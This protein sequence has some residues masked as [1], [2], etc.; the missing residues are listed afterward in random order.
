MN[1]QKL[2]IA[3]KPIRGAEQDLLQ[4]AVVEGAMLVATDTGKMY[5]DANGKRV[6][7]GGSGSPF[8][9]AEA[10]G[11]EPDE[12]G[13]YTLSFDDLESK[14]MLPQVDGLIINSD[15]AF[16]RI[17]EV[18]AN[19]QTMLCMMIAVSGTN[20]DGPTGGGKA[21]SIKGK[22]LS[23]VTLVNGQKMSAYF[24]ATAASLGDG[25]YL[26]D[27]LTISWSLSVTATGVVYDSG[28]FKVASGVEKEFEFGSR[29]RESTGTTLSVYATGVNSGKS[30]IITY[31][32]TTVELLLYESE[33]FSNITPQTGTFTYY[34]NVS[35]SVEKILDFYLDGEL[36]E[37]QNLTKSATGEQ[38]CT[39]RNVSH[40]YHTISVNLSQSI[41][42]EHGVGVNEPLEFEIAVNNGGT[43]PIIWLGAYNKEYYNYDAI[44]IPYRVFDP[45]GGT[46][47]VIFVKGIAE[48]GNRQEDTAATKFSIWQI[49]DATL[50]VEN[51]YS[52]R[53]EKSV[54]VEG[55]SKFVSR[56]IKFTVAKDPTRD[57]S[58]VEQ[59]QLLL[60]FDAAGRSNNEPES[61]RASW[62]YKNEAKP[63]MQ[64][65]HGEFNGFNWYNNGWMLDENNDTM[66]RIS[67]GAQFS[68]PIG[69][70]ILNNAANASQQ[71]RTFEFEFKIR[72]VQDYTNL[73]KEYTRYSGDL[74]YWTAFLA[75]LKEAKEGYY[76]NYDNFLRNELSKP[77]ATTTYDKLSENFAGIERIVSGNTPFCSYY[78]NNG[79]GF[80]LGPQDGFFA[81]AENILN[82][83]Y[84]E[85]KMINLSVVFSYTDQR[86]YFYLQ[87]ILT[88]VCKITDTGAL[89]IGASNIV[90]N[91]QY[92]DVDLYKMRIYD[93]ALSVRDVLINYSVD[94]ASVL[95]YDHTTRLISYNQ[96]TGEYQ[97]NYSSMVEWNEDTAHNDSQLMPYIIF[98]SGSF[99]N[100]LPYSKADKKVV[101][102]TF[103]NTGLDRAYKNGTLEELANQMADTQ[104][105]A[106][107]EEGLSLVQ[108]YY[109]YHCPS[110]V[111]KEDKVE[112]A[113][114][115]T[116]S[117]FYPRRNYK[118][119]FKGTD[120]AGEDY[121][122]MFMN[123]GPFAELYAAGIAGDNEALAKCQLEFFHYNNYHVGTN[124]FTMKIDF[125]ES[126]G[127]YNMGLA[128]LVHSA[129]SKHPTDDYNKAGAFTKVSYKISNEPTANKD[130]QYFK[131]KKGSEKAKFTESE[132]YQPGKY[133]LPEYSPYTF[134][135]EEVMDFRTNVQGFPV[136]AFWKYG[137]TNNDYR[138]IGRYNM[139]L[140]K[141]SD[142]VYNFKPSKSIANAFGKI[143]K[144]VQTTVRKMTECWE[145]SDNQRTFCSFKDPQ[146]RYH[147]GFDFYVLS[148]A[149]T[150]NPKLSYFYDDCG[151]QKVT[152]SDDL[153]YEPNKYYTRSLN[154]KGSCPAA[155]DSFE[156][157]YNDNE[158]FLDYIYD[159]VLNGD[160]YN[161]LLED[162]TNT[163]LA[164]I[165]FRSEEMFDIYK[166]W[167]KACQWVWSTNTDVVPT[168]AERLAGKETR[169]IMDYQDAEG[170]E[171]VEGT[172]YYNKFYMPIKQADI[173]REVIDGIIPAG[174]FIGVPTPVQYDTKTYV[175]DTKEYRNAKFTNELA[176]HFDLQYCLVYFVM[177]ET[178]LLYDSRGKNCMMASW[179]PHTEGG[180]Y[181]WYPIFYDADTQ[182]GINNTG[183]PSFDYSENAT[184]DGTFST[185]DSVLW[186]NLYNNFFQQIT[187]K[188][189][190][191]RHEM[192]NT[193][194]TG[195]GPLYD[196]D[197][198]EKW[199]LA[200]AD[201][202]GFATKIGDTIHGNLEM[203][204]DRPLCMFNMDE[205]YKFISITNDKIQYQDGTGGLSTDTAGT[206]FYALQGD[207]SLSR[208]QFLARRLSF[209]DSWLGEGDFSR[210]GANGNSIHGRF[211]ANTA[212]LF[213]DV[214]VTEKASDTEMSTHKLS[215]SPYY[216]TDASGNVIK[217][218]K[219]YGVK[220][221][222]LDADFYVELLPYQK[223]YV[224][225][226]TDTEAYPSVEY[227]D[228]PVRYEVPEGQKEGVLKSP[229]LSESLIY[230][231]GPSA[232]KD[233][234]DISLMYWSE[235][236]AENAPHLERILLGNDHPS[237]YNK[238]LKTPGF[239]ANPADK[240][241]GKPLLK[242]VNMSGVQLVSSA[243]K[244]Y[245]FTSCEKMEIFKAA[246][247][248]IASVKFADGVALH[249]LYLPASV[250]SLKLVEAANLD[251]ILDFDMGAMVDAAKAKTE[252]L[253]TKPF[254]DAQNN[255]YYSTYIPNDN[256]WNARRGLY[257]EGLTNVKEVVP[258][259]TSCSLSQLE[260][261][262]GSLGYGSYDLV[263]KLYKIF[264][265]GDSAG[266]KDLKLSLTDVEWSPYKK[267]DPGVMKVPGHKYYTDDGHYGFV[268]YSKSDASWQTD[269]INGEVYDYL[270]ELAE[271]SHKI[272]DIQMLKDFIENNQFK[273]TT[274]TGNSTPVIT[275]SM[276]VD[277]DVAVDEDYIRNTLLTDA[278]FAGSKLDIR[279]KK[280]T[281]GYTA[282]FLQLE[283]DG[284]YK[285]IDKQVL[286]SSTIGSINRFA[287]PYTRYEAKRDNYDFH[288]WATQND[289]RYVIPESEWNTSDLTKVTDT[290]VH[291]YTFYAVFTRHEFQ[292]TFMSGTNGSF[293]QVDKKGVLFGDFIPTPTVVPSLDESDLDEEERYRFLG[294]TQDKNAV[295][296]Q[297][298]NKAKLV[299]VSSIQASV[300]TT[301]YA[302]FVKESVYDSATDDKY[303]EFIE[304]VAV[305]DDF[306]ESQYDAQGYGIKV[307]DG[308]KLSGKVT[309]PTY[310]NGIPIVSTDRESFVDQTGI[311]HVFFFKEEGK[312]PK[313][314][315]IDAL[316]FSGCSR[317]KHVEIPTS[318]RSIM[319]NAFT[320]CSSLVMNYIGG[321]VALIA[322]NAFNQALAAPAGQ[323]A[324]ANFTIGGCVKMLD[325]RAFSNNTVLI[326][327]F[328]IGGPNDPSQ[329]TTVGTPA[330]IENTGQEVESMEIYCTADD[331][332]FFNSLK[333]SENRSGSDYHFHL[334]SVGALSIVTI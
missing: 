74:Q 196:V 50:N 25:E 183:I 239:N 90:F 73:I 324:L 225:L 316:T 87:G 164:D 57:L 109:K 147:F 37:S 51:S 266:Q 161:D 232:L 137:G 304:N 8:I 203:R 262:G 297:S 206:Y 149:E 201:E 208:Q 163:Q 18:D 270:P 237:F 92:C 193:R 299:N 7:I 268:E 295:I 118:I 236:Y 176:Q 12:W 185:S 252:G 11:L 190:E 28:T 42:G 154:A 226:G 212:N 286:P 160:V 10:E 205:W 283:P 331:F 307:K 146:G 273:N 45:I 306:G 101:G 293:T 46:K 231:Y 93:S 242:E 177:T 155:A 102:V 165:D 300:D 26:D 257:I 139:L 29:L 332:D 200:D 269:L 214:W 5:M 156:Y 67:N 9:Y 22:P 334:K 141:G 76:D 91:S 280:V 159:P 21:M 238:A 313:L 235:F 123:R 100:R 253:S 81:S 210:S 38:K 119:K 279:F 244:N 274:S 329:L 220:T 78:D 290:S 16:F 325:T 143:K 189:S 84:V 330:I 60:S 294:W 129:Y 77:D 323:G 63:E 6:S 98:D 64:A 327:K 275:G 260:L 311:T 233:I 321:N 265:F 117:Q 309:I 245:D 234:G 247:S 96:N 138:F 305:W 248:N 85:G 17:L 213:S 168:E 188:Y 240:G 282:T 261:A 88:A 241:G 72:N 19:A 288:G 49:T 158:D 140:D 105:A 276:Y 56:D 107:A 116:S 287:N 272:T 197:H 314:R 40:G 62:T 148:T 120:A 264:K 121:I 33:K 256:K 114:Q 86:I 43:D 187:A 125:M 255:E 95:D 191:L 97:L 258:N 75:Q 59:T 39:F 243:S 128:N 292:M 99:S 157:R 27:E 333:V 285:V 44:K 202:A 70:M 199:Y 227:K 36:V 317:L 108:Y 68:I 4:L 122:Y 291:D 115:G 221:N 195:K 250:T 30:K 312:E 34:C 173:D 263:N 171:Y 224:T 48:I 134:S 47:E 223:S 318:V 89:E 66:L 2:D 150:Y 152:F 204:G 328:T 315:R 301:F 127:T 3:L 132:P 24:T 178:L 251:T 296:A 83:K 80:L 131:D 174:Y 310:H 71:S 110:F 175:Y 180:D 172:Q 216:K 79:R 289:E 198:I 230:V 322:Q 298:A 181:I 267:L 249:T 53:V 13:T 254:E 271:A 215:V 170:T 104:K 308:I 246:R 217:D 194:Y 136:M 103:V 41:D 20:T 135:P 111:S 94:H 281:P 130:L 23:T 61:Q 192:N 207:R 326:K 112:I 106:A 302:V 55:E 211:G 151:R 142:E 124:K 303:F 54:V 58:L 278:N 35:G 144:G 228:K 222:Y 186:M 113:V 219:G 319:D 145:F 167:E 179:G 15:G 184:I 82:V 209:V 259:V 218:S 162:Y 14:D 153:V 65:L 69:T 166:H 126:S 229:N 31:E 277:N 169:L 182:L 284:T 320:R 1:S 52:I 32:V 133:Y